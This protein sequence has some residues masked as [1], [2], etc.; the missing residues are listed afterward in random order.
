MRYFRG[1]SRFIMALVMLVGFGAKAEAGVTVSPTSIHFGTKAVGTVS[2]PA[3]V[4]LSNDGSRYVKFGGVS[5]KSSQFSYSGP[6]GSFIL[7]PGQS[8]SVTVSFQPTLAQASSAR[9]VFLR[10]NGSR[11]SVALYGTGIAPDATAQP[12]VITTQPVSRSVTAGQTATFSVSV[13][14]TAPFTYQWRKN[15]TNISGATSSSYTTP[16]TTTADNG[17]QFT[18]QVTNAA[19]SILSNAAILSVS[20]P[21]TMLTLNPTSLN[22][23]SVNIGSSA[24]QGIAVSNT[25]SAS[26]TISGISYSGAGFTASGLGGQ[27]LAPG[28]TANLNVTF[29]PTASGTMSGSV[30]VSSNASNSPSTVAVSG[31]GVQQIAHTATLSWSSVSPAVSGYRVYSSTTPGGPYNRLTSSTLSN[32]TYTDSS[33]QSG[34]TYYYVVTSVD[35]NSVESAFSNQVSAQIP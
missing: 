9:L 32:L 14:G 10:N 27:I 8:L 5:L 23:G 11:Y 1:N 28:Q 15:G 25:G 17:A 29:T 33:V 34:K 20:A 16:A 31:S 12:P 24:T 18:V 2:A 22:F 35:S 21:S 3:T 13:S 19:G 26:L 6:A 7:G 30:T 4:K